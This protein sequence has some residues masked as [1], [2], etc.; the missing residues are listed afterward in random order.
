MTGL[1][2]VL[3]AAILGAILAG[4]GGAVL[5]GGGLCLLVLAYYILETVGKFTRSLFNGGKDP[6][7]PPEQIEPKTPNEDYWQRMSS[8]SPH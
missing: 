3:L 6:H 2:A 1:I 4:F 8:A 7:A 5:L